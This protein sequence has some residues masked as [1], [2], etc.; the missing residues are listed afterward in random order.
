MAHEV[1]QMFS[2][3]E[4]PW[5]GLG[6]IIKEAPTVEEGIRLAGLDWKVEMQDLFMA[7]GQKVT[8]K[9]ITRMDTLS[10]LGFAGPTYHPLQNEEAFKF[11]NPFLEAGEASLETAGSLQG[12]KIIWVMA[13]LNRKD[14]DV[15]GGDS[16]R[17]YMILSNGHNGGRATRVS[18]S[19]V[20]V[21][22]MNTLGMS[23]YNSSFIRVFHSKDILENL[24]KIQEIVNVAD[25][26]FNATAAQYQELAKKSVSTKDLEKF[27]KIVFFD[28]KQ[29]ESERMKL[30]YNKMVDTITRLFEVGRGADLK[31]SKGTAWGLYNAATE[32]LSWESAK[33]ED[34]RFANLWFGQGKETNQKAFE[35]LK[36]V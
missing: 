16:V 23:D 3:N 33:S 34:R 35:Y 28:S 1:E 9:A 30:N 4:I 17:K 32:Y 22:C 6:R 36:A 21:V 11:F 25:S 7:N 31:T 20:R 29:I 15:G 13:K 10:P 18:F 14:I 26:E 8:E 24:S 19:P 5:H 12:G 2:V 27:V